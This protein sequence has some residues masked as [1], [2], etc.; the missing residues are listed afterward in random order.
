MMDYASYF[1][2]FLF[3]VGIIIAIYI[4]RGYFKALAYEQEFGDIG[5]VTGGL[6]LFAVVFATGSTTGG[7]IKFLLI[8]LTAGFTTSALYFRDEPPLGDQSDDDFLTGRDDY[9]RLNLVL[10]VGLS[11]AVLV[12]PTESGVPRIPIVGVTLLVLSSVSAGV[13]GLSV[14]VF[15]KSLS[16]VRG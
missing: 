4:T 6:C 8:C 11:I 14:L 5:I 3:S 10:I 15:R 16:D 2:H 13:A 7:L 9:G 1:P 12:F